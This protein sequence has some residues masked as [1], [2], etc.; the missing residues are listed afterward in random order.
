MLI[1]FL[2][3]GVLLGALA[4][5]AFVVFSL[6]REIAADIGP[7]LRRIQNQLDTLEAVMNLALL[8]RYAELSERPGDIPR[9]RE[10]EIDVPISQGPPGPDL[11]DDDDDENSALLWVA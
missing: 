5:S 9:R 3:I 4:G 10:R 6:R 7:Q 1:L 2:I 8:T 11:E